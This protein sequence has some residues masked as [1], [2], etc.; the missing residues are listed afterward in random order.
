[1][2]MAHRQAPRNQ[3]RQTGPAALDYSSPAMSSAA[4]AAPS[5]STGR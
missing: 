1:M 5:L 2:I 3:N 4:R